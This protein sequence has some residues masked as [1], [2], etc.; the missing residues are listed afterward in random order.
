MPDGLWR[1][2]QRIGN[3]GV[4]DKA[5]QWG[6]NR[7]ALV[8]G[9]GARRQVAPTLTKTIEVS[10]KMTTKTFSVRANTTRWGKREHRNH[11]TATVSQTADDSER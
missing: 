2:Q 9:N 6:T 8:I 11:V 10:Q 4:T 1:L 5:D 7:Q 3:A